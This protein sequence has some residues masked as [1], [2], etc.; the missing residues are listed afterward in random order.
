MSVVALITARGGSKG[1]PRK[2]VLPLCGKPLIAWT[3]EAALRATSV[4]RVVLSSDDDEI[5]SIAARFGCEVLFKRP[6]ELASDTA[7]SMDVV[8]HALAQLTDAQ[9]IVLLQPTSPLRTHADIDAAVSRVRT[10]DAPACVSVCEVSESPYWMY[11][12]GKQGQIQ[13]LMPTHLPPQ[14]RQ[15]LEPIYRLN[16]AVYVAQ[17]AW[18]LQNGG[19]VSAQ[20]VAH[21]MPASR[22]IDIDTAAD[23]EWAANAM[24]ELQQHG[25]P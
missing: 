23:F 13:P 1:L 19:F 14:R 18:L 25:N 4:D 2:N 3:I 8:R 5:S 12:I 21:C 10:G 20:T 9:M 16:G 6:A 7:S 15:D 22:S 24:A 17:S 11:R